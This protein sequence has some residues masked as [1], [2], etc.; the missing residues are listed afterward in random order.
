MYVGEGRG[1]VPATAG[2]F[3]VIRI[4]RYLE[5]IGLGLEEEQKLRMQVLIYLS[6]KKRYVY[7]RY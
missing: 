3:Y 1:W 5:K 2:L 7:L 4:L 6:G